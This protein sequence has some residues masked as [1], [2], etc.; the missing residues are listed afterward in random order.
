[1]AADRVVLL[2][3]EGVIRL[4]A[5]LVEQ[6]ERRQ[7]LFDNIQAANSNNEASDSGEYEEMRDELVYAEARMRE[8]EQ[9]LANAE[10]VERGSKDGV[11]RIGSHLTLK[12]DGETEEWVLVSSEEASIHDGDV[13]V[14]S[15]VGQA[16][17][18][19]KVGDTR[20]V[21]TPGGE[22]LYEV[23]AVN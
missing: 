3:P 13:S 5:E 20:T 9:I 22:V 18:G 4:Q 15:P 8:L 11:A 23:L 16:L 14:D 1:M 12:I 17:V 7:E 2:T 10:V 19:C 6:R 21:T